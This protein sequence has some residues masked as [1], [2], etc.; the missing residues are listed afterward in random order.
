MQ[1][2][3]LH[4]MWKNSLIGTKEFKADTGEHVKII[5][6][7]LHNH[8]G[9]PDF[10]NA[11]IEIDRTVWAGNVEIHV[12]ASDWYSHHHDSNRSYDNVIL[13]RSG[14]KR[15]PD[16]A[17]KKRSKFTAIKNIF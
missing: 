10:T 14:P 15:K 11:R 5:D 12:L 13:Y 3:L 17:D 6:P 8:D 9:G 16:A 7:G 2:A 1:E 4:Y